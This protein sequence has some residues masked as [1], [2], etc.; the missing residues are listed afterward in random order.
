MM[1]KINGRK[2]S[3]IFVLTLF[4]LFL[5]L[6]SSALV[7][8]QEPDGPPPDGPPPQDGRPPNPDGDLVRQLNLTPDQIGKIRAI[9]EQNREARR[10]LGMRVRA[11][12]MALDRAIYVE[13]A[14]EAVVEQRAR[15]LAEAQA[16][17]I[18]LQAMTELGIRRILTPE[19]LVTLRGLRA[20]AAERQGRDGRRRRDAGGPP[21]DDGN[22]S[23]LRR[24]LRRGQ[25]APGQ[26]NSNSDQGL[27]PRQPP[28]RP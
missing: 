10:T 18:R 16:A 19:Q 12:R 17:N 27:S 21:V 4:L 11:A 5:A 28:G 15:D 24:G 3:R 1:K 14:D 13:N 23:P 25:G 6:S 26:T 22:P 2:R 9:R 20:A 7:R 8:A